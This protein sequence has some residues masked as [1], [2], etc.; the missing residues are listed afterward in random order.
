MDGDCDV[1]ERVDGSREFKGDVRRY[2][3][4]ATELRRSDQSVLNTFHA[5]TRRLLSDSHLT[6]RQP[7][8]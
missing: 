1:N 8:L 3:A 4:A 2:R 6:A 7:E 5:P